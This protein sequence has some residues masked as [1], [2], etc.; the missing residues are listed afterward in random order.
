MRDLV[1]GVD[2][3]GTRTRVLVASR[4]GDVLGRSDGGPGNP[5]AHGVPAALESVSTAIVKALGDADPGRVARVLVAVAGISGPGGPALADALIERLAGYGF[6]C[7]VQLRADIAAAYA[8]GT[9]ADEGYVLV[10]GTGAVAG[11]V[12]AGELTRFVDGNGWLLGDDGGGFWIGRQAVRAVLAA[13]DGSGEPTAL[14][15]QLAR[16]WAIA[17]SR[18]AVLAAAYAEPPVHLS[19]LAPLVVA[20]H[21]HGDPVASRI[22]ASAAE[23]LTRALAALA[24]RPGRPLVLAGGVLTGDSPVAARV[25]EVVDAR[26]S[27]APLPARDTAAGAAWLA[28]S[29]MTPTPPAGTHA[30]LIDT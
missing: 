5:T 9:D 1:V 23:A 26:W 30:R 7:P 14:V 10:A 16:A 27:L 6:R 24:P 13:L 2:A 8:G 3:G 17:P 28:L 21:D 20:A 12:K 18:D 25:V 4:R 11:E 15:D 19:G 29:Q 22:V